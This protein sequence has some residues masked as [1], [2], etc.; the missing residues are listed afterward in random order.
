MQLK[1]ILRALKT[2]EPAISTALG[3]LVVLTIGILLVN[4]FRGQDAQNLT[5]ATQTEN[6]QEQVSLPAKHTVAQGEHLW[7]IAEKYYKSGYNWVD[8]AQANNLTNADVVETGMELTIPQIE[9]KTSTLA[10]VAQA[11]PAPDA[12]A[13]PTAPSPPT[14]G[15]DSPQVE[16]PS[17]IGDSTY[18]TVKGDHL[19]GIAVRAYGDGYKWVEIAKANNLTNPNLIFV[20][21]ELTLP[22]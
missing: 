1:S 7:K 20:D 5:T 11:P 13:A 9:S 6:T 21:Q 18:K 17:T 22:R 10:E 14:A 4:Y 16:T 8:I 3:A 15:M 19:W 12:P 2:N